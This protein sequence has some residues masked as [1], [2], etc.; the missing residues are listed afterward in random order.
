[1][2]NQED[3]LSIRQIDKVR[4]F[5]SQSCDAMYGNGSGN[6]NSSS[7]QEY[8]AHPG[9][10]LTPST[11][12]A[13]SILSESCE[14]CCSTDE[15]EPS[16]FQYSSSKDLVGTLSPFAYHPSAF[17]SRWFRNYSNYRRGLNEIQF[18]LYLI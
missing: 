9:S 3:I 16:E 17:L 13:P 12:L 7:W 18:H 1:M 6:S 14:I 15:E 2:L 5:L 10:K 8:S 4:I 11:E